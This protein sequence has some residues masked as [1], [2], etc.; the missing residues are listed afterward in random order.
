[1]EL[2]NWIPLEKINWSSL[3]LNESD[4]AIR[5][6]EA[7][8]DNMLSRNPYGLIEKENIKT[9]TESSS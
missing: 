6:L 5:L 9:I 8:A 2:R 1:M 7:N 4:G 3:S